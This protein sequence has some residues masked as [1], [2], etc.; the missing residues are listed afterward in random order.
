MMLVWLI[1]I[2]GIGGLDTCVLSR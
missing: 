2:S 1:L